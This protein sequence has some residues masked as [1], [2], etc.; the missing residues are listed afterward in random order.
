M[1][2]SVLDC[3]LRDGGYVNHF[4]FGDKVAEAIING[5]MTS[6]IEYVEIGFLRD[7]K[8]KSETTIFN[9]FD[10]INKLLSPVHDWARTKCF[11]MIKYGAYSRDI[12]LKKE[13]YL[14]GIR[15][16]CKK[17]Q[18]DEALEY[19]HEIRAKGY[20]VSINPTGIHQY[21]QNEL[22]E[23]ISK[24]NQAHPDIFAMVDTLGLLTPP[25][26]LKLCRCIDE[27][28]DK[29][30][31]LGLHSHNNLQLSFPNAMAI[32]AEVMDREIIIDSSV[33]G[34]G[35]GAGN[36]CSELLLQYLN[37]NF[38]KTYNLVPILKIIDEQI[39]KIY[40]KTPWGY[41][42][43][44]YLAASMRCHPNYS[45]FLMDKA[46]ISVENISEILAMIPDDK[47]SNYDEKLIQDLYLKYQKNEV[48]DD[49]L[50]EELRRA[51]QDRPILV[52]APGKSIVKEAQ[53]ITDYIAREQ[54]YIIS[55]NFR[56]ADIRVDKVFMSNA[57]RFSEQSDL[58]NVIVTSNIRT[59]DVPK[60]NYGSYLNNSD[61]ADNAALMLLKVL[62]KI[63]VNSVS[64]A[65]LD[66]F[67]SDNDNYYAPEMINNA[68]LGEETDRR[69][70]IMVEMLHKFP[71]RI[72]FVTASRYEN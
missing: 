51:V 4:A 17:D 50:L 62:M 38:E 2:I 15:V 28:L 49:A 58:S 23:I 68:R 16:T 71:I 67:A 6:G 59:N 72:Q 47:R 9:T 10:D 42:V 11:A 40:A 25:E 66:G 48:N 43:P 1:S 65:G 70:D 64:F 35:R 57:R 45:S 41:N 30:I 8:E 37:D 22:K 3:T 46:S 13:T 19:T 12:P 5:I 53:K 21:T 33:R 24:V 34:M 56:P 29:D 26:L 63:G 52:L 39:N 69:N 54:P 18:L 61:M 31:T 36:L 14:H 60:L 7:K 55:I 20:I 27:N 44:Y 32:S